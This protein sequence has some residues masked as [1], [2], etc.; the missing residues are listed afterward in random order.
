MKINQTEI[1]NFALWEKK[2]S[3]PRSLYSFDL[4]LTARCN[5]NCRHC[6]INLPANDQ[7]AKAQELAL[8]E[9]EAI[10]DQAVELG[11]VWVMLTGGE[12][13]LRPD[14]AEIYLVFKRKGLAGFGVHQRHPGHSRTC[15]AVP[16][17]SPPGY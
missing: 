13:L 15:G 4:E 3:Q 12:P 16:K 2:R 17:V 8:P 7:V 5:N 10:A 6:Y 9:I 1:Q 14:F 11:A